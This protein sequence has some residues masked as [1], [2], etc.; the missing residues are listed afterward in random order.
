MKR[1]SWIPAVLCLAACE[2]P[3]KFPGDEVMGRFDFVAQ[4]AAVGCALS[5]VVPTELRFSAT[6][7]RASDGSQYWM[8]INGVS[9]DAT[10]DGQYA[11][12]TR[13]APRVFPSCRLNADAGLCSEGAS[14][15][16]SLRIAFLSRGQDEALGSTCPTH[17]LG[18]PLPSSADG[19]VAPPGLKTGSFDALRA[20]GEMQD[21]VVPG[22]DCV[23]DACQ[24][25]YNVTGVRR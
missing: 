7:S 1:L 8:T 21:L 20:C 13:S 14:L 24:V 15:R 16:E 6:F 12:T 9:A 18:A 11:A 2:E 22:A 3:S 5:E 4:P 19:T 10:F 17:P 23:C 25:T